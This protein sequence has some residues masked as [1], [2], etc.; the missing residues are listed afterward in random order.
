MVDRVEVYLKFVRVKRPKNCVSVCLCVYVS[1]CL[2]V[3][4]CLCVSV[5]VSLCLCVSVCVCLDG[6]NSFCPHCVLRSSLCVHGTLGSRTTRYYP[7]ARVTV[8]LPWTSTGG[9]FSTGG[10]LHISL[11]VPFMKAHT[12][13]T[14]DQRKGLI[15]FL[16]PHL[17]PTSMQ[18]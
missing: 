3:C 17:W 15:P 2:C 8:Y 10:T 7:P 14:R 11:H 13:N 4:L 12:Q 16:F 6:S 18:H 1:V 9:P 5:C